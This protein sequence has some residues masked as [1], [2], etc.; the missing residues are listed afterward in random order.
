MKHYTYKLFCAGLLFVMLT[1]SAPAVFAAEKININTATVS[2]LVVLNGIGEKTALK[3]VAHRE[4]E[5][6]F[7][8]I[9]NISDVKGIGEKSFAKF[10]DQITV[11]STKSK[12]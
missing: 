1:V 12:K 5:G 7:K 2:E 10:S 4:A 6:D 9:E 11:E 3:I 8:A